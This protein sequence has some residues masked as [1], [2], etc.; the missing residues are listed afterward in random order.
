[1]NSYRRWLPAIA[2]VVLS[3]T[4]GYTWVLAK[5]G[6]AHAP[7]FAFAA[8]R[9]LGSAVALFIALRLTGRKSTMLLKNSLVKPGTLARYAIF[10]GF[11][12]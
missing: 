1:M 10:A 2:L 9:C 3:L 5:H 11:S 8:E 6:L 12:L 4:W 7:P